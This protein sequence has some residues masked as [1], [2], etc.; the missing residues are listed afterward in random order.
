MPQ[1]ALGPQSSSTVQVS[2]S[3]PSRSKPPSTPS[4][5]H[6]PAEAL[7]LEPLVHDTHDEPGEPLPHCVLLN[8][9]GPTHTVPLQQPLQLPGPQ[10]LPTHWPALQV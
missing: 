2:G 7:Q 8:D 3:P 10:V 9:A 1:H 5:T 6:W 4:G